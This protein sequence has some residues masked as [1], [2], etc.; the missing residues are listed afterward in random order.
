MLRLPTRVRVRGLLSAT[1]PMGMPL[2]FGL[3]LL[4]QCRNTCEFA[5]NGV[6]DDGGTGERF[7]ESEDH[8]I[9]SGPPVA[10]VRCDYGTDCED[11]GTRVGLPS[12]PPSPPTPPPPV[13]SIVGVVA[14]ALGVLAIIA[15]ACFCSCRGSQLKAAAIGTPHTRMQVTLSHHGPGKVPGQQDQIGRN[16][17][18]QPQQQQPQPPPQRPRPSQ[19]QQHAGDATAPAV[20]SRAG[21]TKTTPIRLASLPQQPSPAASQQAP[22]SPG[23]TT[24][25]PPASSTS[26]FIELLAELSHRAEDISHRAAQ[27]LGF[28]GGGGSPLASGSSPPNERLPSVSEEGVATATAG[29]ASGS[30]GVTVGPECTFLV[31]PPSRRASRTSRAGLRPPLQPPE[32]V[33]APPARPRC[34]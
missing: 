10:D 18:Q 21:S 5:S 2:A 11:C 9:G 33:E 6:C 25:S 29:G 13:L 7:A 34:V 28:E 16:G 27:F 19:Q 17:R 30:V 15:V 8:S 32:P 1:Y 12:K 23:G 22:S 4:G 26:P 3:L 20:A 31:M 24:A 14:T